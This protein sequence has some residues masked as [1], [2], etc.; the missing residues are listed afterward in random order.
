ML[1]TLAIIIL[2]VALSWWRPEIGMAVAVQ[3]YLI[4]SAINKPTYIGQTGGADDDPLLSLVI[5]CIIFGVIL[6][7]RFQKGDSYERYN[8]RVLDTL[9]YLLGVVLIV[10]ALYSP[11]QNDALMVSAK[12]FA[13]GISFYYFGRL[14]F[15]K[16]MDIEKATSNFLIATWAM[17]LL[18]GVYAYFQS[19]GVDYFR[20]TIGNA[21]PIPF[22]LLIAAGVLINVYWLF[23]PSLKIKIRMLLFTSLLILMII[24]ISTNTRGTILSLAVATIFMVSA[25]VLQGKVRIRSLFFGFIGL[26]SSLIVITQLIPDTADTVVDNL[27]LIISE[28]QGVSIDERAMAH[29]DALRIFS[30][31]ILLGV[32]TAGFKS[33]SEI[34]YPHNAMLEMLS[35]NGLLGG[36][37]LGLVYLVIIMLLLKIIVKY[38]GLPLLI[39]SLVV[40]CMVEMQFSFT[41]WMHKL[42]FLFCGLMVSITIKSKTSGKNNGNLLL[43]VSHTRIVKKTII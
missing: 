23:M 38:N 32:G 41:L 15:S 34:E 35:E 1:Y 26:L 17:A 24:F 8:I 36:I 33:F 9:F 6:L 22:S 40:L 39:G 25:P 21:H 30:E 3:S 31:N 16:H 28:E 5:P 14:Y 27:K 11:L 10:G 37:A 2:I 12:Y 29:E 42:F 13:L 43:P 19:F 18:L 7:K 20:L 4:R